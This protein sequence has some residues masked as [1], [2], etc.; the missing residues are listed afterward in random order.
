MVGYTMVTMMHFCI[1]NPIHSVLM[2]LSLVCVTG[3]C[4]KLTKD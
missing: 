1:L 2:C 4:K 3:K